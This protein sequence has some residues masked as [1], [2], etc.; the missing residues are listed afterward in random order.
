MNACICNLLLTALM[1]TS[2]KT[3]PLSSWLISSLLQRVTFLSKTSVW[4]NAAINLSKDL[5]SVLIL[6]LCLDMMLSSFPVKASYDSILCIHWR[7]ADVSMLVLV[8][9]LGV[10]GV[11]ISIQQ[12]RCI[13]IQRKRSLYLKIR[14]RRFEIYPWSTHYS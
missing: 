11:L 14:R 10:F 4:L 1:H 13:C 5:R 2:L 8:V 9:E 3:S 12:K 7:T 6:P